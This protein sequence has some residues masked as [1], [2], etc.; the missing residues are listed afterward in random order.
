MG[1]MDNNHEPIIRIMVMAT[2][3]FVVLLTVGALLVGLYDP[4]VDNVQVIEMLKQPFSTA[5]GSLITY[6]AMRKGR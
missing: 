4:R 5:I 1:A 6:I 2:I 3:C